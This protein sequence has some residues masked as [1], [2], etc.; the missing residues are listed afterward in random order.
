[1]RRSQKPPLILRLPRGLREQPA[2][3]FI[4]SLI[5]LV[6]LSYLTGF[7]ES[8][9]SQAIGMTGLKVWGGI[10]AASGALLIS[11]T[12][13]ARPALEKLSLRA[14]TCSLL[15]YGGY[16]LTVSSF[17]RAAMTVVLVILLAGI[18]E[19][20]TWH[21]TILIRRSETMTRMLGAE[22]ND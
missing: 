4:G 21:L 11:A 6:G 12:V 20:R 13:Y 16:L 9:I 2:W 14:M 8:V 22:P 10:L 18:A 5:F 17:K 3:V 7:T 19:I 15:A 1:M